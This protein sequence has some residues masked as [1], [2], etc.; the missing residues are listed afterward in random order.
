[1]YFNDKETWEVIKDLQSRLYEQFGIE[2]EQTLWKYSCSNCGYEY[3]NV[4]ELDFDEQERVPCC[5]VCKN[6][7]ESEYEE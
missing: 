2:E 7:I 4:S 1:M 6:L 3:T 5:P